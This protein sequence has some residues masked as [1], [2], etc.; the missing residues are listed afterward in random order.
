MATEKIEIWKYIKGYENL[1]QISNLGRVKSMGNGNSSNSKERILKP[2]TNNKGYLYIGLCKDGKVKYYLVH[3]LVANSFIDNPDNYN[4]VNHIN[5]DKTDNRVNN[6]EWCSREYNINYGSRIERARNSNINH[7][8]TS[9]PIYSVNKTTN[10]II[11]YQSIN[12]AERI[13][14]IYSSN[15]CSCLKGKLKSTGGYKWHYAS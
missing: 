12:D 6:L 8:S 4:E 11:Y 13:T 7:P 5:E 2:T 15:I 14:G 3:R 10:E 9:K 1:Y